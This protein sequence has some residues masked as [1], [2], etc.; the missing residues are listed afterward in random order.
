MDILVWISAS[1]SGH[2]CN[3]MAADNKAIEIAW[4]I[5]WGFVF[6]GEQIKW[7][8]IIGALIVIVGVIV[9]VK[10]DG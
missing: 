7:N 6:F 5:L 4:G 10:S 3:C 2:L 8:M 9:V 1:E